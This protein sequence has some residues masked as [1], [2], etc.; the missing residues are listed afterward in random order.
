MWV[1]TEKE[2]LMKHRVCIQL[3]ISRCGFFFFFLSLLFSE[4][5][6]ILRSY[7]LKSHIYFGQTRI[8]ATVR[9][10]WSRNSFGSGLLAPATA[11]EGRGSSESQRKQED[12]YVQT[13]LTFS[14]IERRRLGFF[15]F[16]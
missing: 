12:S 4:N 9:L 7:L 3:Q 10:E 14:A 2:A 5:Y 13:S 15:F 6:G 11:A 8:K 1:P 16:F